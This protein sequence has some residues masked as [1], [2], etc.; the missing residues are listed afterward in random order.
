MKDKQGRKIFTFFA[1]IRNKILVGVLLA[2]PIMATVWIFK[3]LLNLSTAW[4]PTDFL[5]NYD[6]PLKGY[7]MQFIVLI[8]VLLVF[9]FLGFLVQNF[10]GKKIYQITDKLL[11][12]IPL[13]KN[14]YVFIRQLCEWVAK[15]RSTIFDSV[16]LFEY[17]RKGIYSIGLVTSEAQKVISSKIRD[18]NGNPRKCVNIFVSTTPNPTS[19]VYVIVPEEDVIKLDMDVN[20]AIN[21][22]ISAGAIIPETDRGYDGQNS[23][24]DLLTRY[25]KKK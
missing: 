22:I 21:Q 17:P 6:F 4:F 25:E 19:G 7:L 5:A 24:M 12:R 14:I 9:Y 16:V 3:F 11:S 18:E 8:C 2:T 13:I 20:A 15:S 10:F 1:G 23:L